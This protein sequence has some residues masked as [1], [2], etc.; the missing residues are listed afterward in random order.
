M[1]NFDGYIADLYRQ[2][3][4]EL[5]SS[6][7]RNLAL[8]LAEEERTGIKYPQWQAMKLKELK[9]FQR[10]N[11]KIIGRKTKGLEK[12]ISEHMQKELKEGSAHEIKIYREA[13]GEGYKSAK[14]VKDSFFK[15]DNEKIKGMINALNNDLSTAN[16]AMFRMA[17]DTYRQVIYK[18]S[19]FMAN[20]AY[21]Y[22]KAYDAATKD[23][24]ERGINCIEYKDGR[25]VNIAD[26]CR[27]A[28]RTSSQRAYMTG[29]GEARKKIGNPLIIITKHNTSC[30]LCRPFERQVLIDDVYSGGSKEDGEYILLSEAMQE[31]L[32]HPNCRHGSDTYYREREE[33]FEEYYK[34]HKE[35]ETAD[36]EG[37]ENNAAH[38]DNMVQKYKRLVTG[39]VDEE[40]I[41]KYQIL[42][43]EWQDKKA[44]FVDNSGESGII[45]TDTYYA[46]LFGKNRK[47][48]GRPNK[49]R[50]EKVGS[51]FFENLSRLPS[52]ENPEQAASNANKNN[53]DD[54]CQRSVPV[55]ELRMRGFDVIASKA[56]DKGDDVGFYAKQVFCDTEWLDCKTDSPRKEIEEFLIGQGYGSRVEIAADIFYSPHMFSAM[57]DNGVV[58]WVDPFSG[59][60]DAKKFFEDFYVDR[61]SYCRIDNADFSNLIKECI[62]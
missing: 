7:K 61:V 54:N 14:A 26:Y 13:L 33:F 3:E 15:V 53:Y 16:A 62:E 32:Y 48:K 40:N 19:F 9:R 42:L 45:N 46:G 52:S 22:K 37:E 23:F 11:A 38:I 59:E 25:R 43:D 4:L 21:T 50:F 34:T 1:D 2:I 35:S 24:L 44:D 27:M 31:G 49:E 41:E 17:N 55:W 10:E 18:Y 20:G 36:N 47:R 6:M 39:S 8:H 51:D 29:Q 30:K 60:I 57:N 12:D 5:I 28:V 56:T 58:K